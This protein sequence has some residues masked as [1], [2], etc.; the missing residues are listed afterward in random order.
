MEDNNEK[1]GKRGVVNAS[2]VLSFA[3]AIFAIFSIAMAGLSMTQKSGV[4]YAAPTALPNNFTFNLLNGGDHVASKD[5]TST[6]IFNVPMYVANNDDDNP[7]FC[8]EHNTPVNDGESYTGGDDINDYGLLYLLNNSY[9]NGV[10]VTSVTG[11]SS[12]YVEAWVTQAAI[13][14]Y[15]Y[16]KDPT[17]TQ[18]TSA[19]YLSQEEIDGIKNATILT[20]FDK[21]NTFGGTVDVYNGA[22]LYTTYVKPLVDRAKLATDVAYLTVS[23]ASDDITLSEDKKFYY[24]SLITVVGDPST[25]LKRYTITLN[26]IDGAKIVDEDGNELT[27]DINPGTKF[28]VRI[29]ADKVKKEVQKVVVSVDAVFNTL[30]GKYYNAAGDYQRVVSVKASEKTIS[31][32]TEVE[33]V[34]TD[35]TGMTA[36]QT[37]YFIGLIVLLCGVGIV[38]ANAKPVQVKQ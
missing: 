21:D 3:V 28:Y 17:A 26:G 1:K 34:G 36:V 31:K 22:N 14:M 16:E 27:G 18:T 33:F 30:E 7:I 2:V 12:K 11:N 32:G 35:N 4:S 20:K 9:A 5:A 24:S 13:W 29:P 8:I 19:N 15:L 23:K 38:Y 37:I 6:K 25:S 10:K